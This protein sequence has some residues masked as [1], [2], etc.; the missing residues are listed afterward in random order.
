MW[1]WLVA[2]LILVY[3]LIFSTQIKT[4]TRETPQK[5]KVSSLQLREIDDHYVELFNEEDDLLEEFLII[6][7]L[8]EEEEEEL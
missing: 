2:G 4:D 3:L 8:D 7:L 5:K 1:I 6:D